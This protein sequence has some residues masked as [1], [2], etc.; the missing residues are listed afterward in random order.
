MPTFDESVIVNGE[1]RINNAGEGAVLLD[2]GLGRSWQL[3]QLG[4][5]P[6][7]QL[8]LAS[9]GGGGNKNFIINTTGRVGIGTTTPETT[10]DVAGSVRVADDVILSG[11]DCAE[12][13]DLDVD[14]ITDPGT[15]MVI[16]PQRR[17]QHCS[18]PY[19][20]RVVGIISGTGD[21]R[22]GIILGRDRSSANK[23]RVPLALAGTVWCN[24]DA[25]AAAIEVGDLLTTSSRPGHAMRASD[26]SRSFGAVVGK[27]MEAMGSGVGKIPVFATLQ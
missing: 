13:F 3:R 8:E 21:W 22:P 16:G 19:D 12:E 4:V 15:V 26:A 11:A 14:A 27:A 20:R 6:S 23:A 5:G 25:T 1:I 17:L 2:L 24:V 9:I 18:G 7:T 10:L